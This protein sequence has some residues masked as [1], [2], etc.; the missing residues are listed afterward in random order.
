VLQVGPYSVQVVVAAVAALVAWRVPLLWRGVDGAG[1]RRAAGFVLDA[2]LVGLLVA[3]IAYVLRWWPD[4]LAAPWSMAAIGDG[5][6]Y[7]WIGLPAALAFLYW[8]TRTMPEL[9]RPALAGVG[10]GMGAWV[11]GRL[12]L[13]ALAGAAPSLPALSLATLDGQPAALSAQVGR[14]VVLNLWATWCPPCRREMP[15]LARAAREHTDVTFLMVNQGE[16]PETIRAFLAGQAL[17]FEHVLVDPLSAS[18][19]ALG[20][21]GLPSTFFFGAD[22]RMVDSH[23]GE[24]TDARLRDLVQRRFQPVPSL[25]PPTRRTP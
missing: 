19:Q 3:R 20:T 21:R 5:G 7:P 13:M 17:D 1:R 18:M 16:T 23:F 11:A 2:L 15:V 22:G 25:H 12:V 6:F 4:Y 24:L 9:R 14:P 10:A 8:R